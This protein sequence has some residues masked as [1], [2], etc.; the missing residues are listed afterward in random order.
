M[1]VSDSFQTLA[2]SD[3]LKNAS[4]SN[5]TCSSFNGKIRDRYVSLSKVGIRVFHLIS[6]SVP[7]KTFIELWLDDGFK[8][9]LAFG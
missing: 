7:L 3:V 5:N 6:D 2:L 9:A 8:H 1:P 4:G